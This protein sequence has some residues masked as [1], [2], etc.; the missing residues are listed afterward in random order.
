LRPSR[1]AREDDVAPVGAASN[2]G[3]PKHG[4]RHHF[5]VLGCL[6]VAAKEQ[7]FPGGDFNH[8][9]IVCGSAAG[10]F[11]SASFTGADKHFLGNHS[12]RL[13]LR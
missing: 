4:N 9:E 2:V 11:G 7:N 3:H 5:D 8:E 12:C 13:W 10:M 1:R 6:S